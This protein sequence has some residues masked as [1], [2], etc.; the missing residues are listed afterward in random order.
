MGGHQTDGRTGVTRFNHSVIVNLILKYHG[1]EGGDAYGRT[2]FGETLLPGFVHVVDDDASFRTA[3]ERR[4][5]KAGCEV[6]TY[7]SAQHLL[8]CLPNERTPSS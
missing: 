5:K 6:A 3:T 7:P 2:V 8:D 1:C 4:L